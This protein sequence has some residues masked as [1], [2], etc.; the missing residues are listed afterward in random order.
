MVETVTECS[1]PLAPVTATVG[2]ALPGRPVILMVRRMVDSWALQRASPAPAANSVSARVAASRLV[3][4]RSQRPYRS[5]VRQGRIDG[6][7]TMIGSEVES[8]NPNT[9]MPR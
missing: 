9:K 3:T 5:S 7:L 4:A 2:R 1:N 6:Q 8:L